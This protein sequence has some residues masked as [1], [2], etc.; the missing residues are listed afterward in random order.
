MTVTVDETNDTPTVVNAVADQS[1]AEDAL[2]TYGVPANTFED[3][4]GDTLTYAITGLPSSGN[5]S[6][7]ASTRTVSKFT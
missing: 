3:L 1:T 5:L 6:F 7:D 2:F 4:D